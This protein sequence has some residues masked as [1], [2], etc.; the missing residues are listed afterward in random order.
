MIEDYIATFNRGA[1]S[2]H[3]NPFAIDVLV[4]TSEEYTLVFNYGPCRV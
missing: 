3:G 2:N 1:V 4:L